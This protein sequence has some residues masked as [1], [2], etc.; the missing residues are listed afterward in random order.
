MSWRPFT[1]YSSWTS[2]WTKRTGQ[3]KTGRRENSEGTSYWRTGRP[4]SY[5]HLDVYKRQRLTRP[6]VAPK[7]YAYCS[8]TAFHP[9]IIPI[10]EAVSYT[11]LLCA[12]WNNTAYYPSLADLQS[13]LT[14]QNSCSSLSLI[15]IS[16]PSDSN[17]SDV[18]G[19]LTG[20]QHRSLWSLG[21]PYRSRCV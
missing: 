2:R 18:L 9:S 19:D 21:E 6:A 8:D 11:H 17:R 12:G 16:R 5:T 10:I 13:S 4:V 15:H 14:I 20:I 3:T 1:E 7:R